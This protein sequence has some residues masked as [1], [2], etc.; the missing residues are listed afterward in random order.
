MLAPTDALQI[1]FSGQL[2]NGVDL[3]ARLG[4]TGQD[5][6]ALLRAGWQRW[7]EG[8]AEHLVGNYALVLRDVSRH[9]TYLARDP[10]GVKPLYYRLDQG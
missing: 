1:T 6:D 4:L 8:L 10:L 2:H 7:G 5:R 3:S 9:L